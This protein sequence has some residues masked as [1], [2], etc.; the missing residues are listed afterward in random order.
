MSCSKSDTR[1]TWVLAGGP[2]ALL[3]S[4][5]MRW[6]SSASSVSA[7]GWLE[8]SWVRNQLRCCR[9]MEWCCCKTGD[10]SL[11]CVEQDVHVESPAA[12][13]HRPALCWENDSAE[14]RARDASGA[15]K[16]DVRKG[17]CKCPCCAQPWGM[18]PSLPAAEL[19]SSNFLAECVQGWISLMQLSEQKCCLFGC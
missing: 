15:C 10:L 5:T 9:T 3:S 4:G 2:G 6:A 18:P 14:P 1:D 12:G 13:L 7:G 16:G 19:H 17:L 11:H 8:K